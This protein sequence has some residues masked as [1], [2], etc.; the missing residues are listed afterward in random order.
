MCKR[1]SNKFGCTHD[2]SYLC[3]ELSKQKLYKMINRV[4][5]RIKVLQIVYSYYQNENSDLGISENELLFS[6][7]KSY[8]LYNY[9]LLLI[10]EVT[11]L[12]Y[13]IIEAKKSKYLPTEEEKNP[14]M[15]LVNNRLATQ[16]SA[17]DSLK[18]YVASEGISWSDDADFVKSVLDLILASDVYKEYIENPDDSYET[19]R[20][21]WRTIFKKVIGGNDDIEEYLGDKSIYW[22]DDIEIVE[23]FVM[24]TINQFEQ[25]KGSRQELLP[26]Y[27]DNEDK[28][29]ATQLFRQSILKGADYRS[30]IDYHMRNWDTE[31]VATM[32]LI[33]MQV[34]LAELL[35]FP[36]IPIEVTLN[37]YI[38]AAKFYSTPN[39]S[40]FVNGVLNS[41][42]EELKS[43]KLLLKN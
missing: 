34:A 15:R 11:N 12:Q 21:F 2:L 36:S 17:N 33:I 8:D 32:D 41:I 28:N 26:M 42:V 18:K 6:L 20:T 24:K 29:F 30:R 4:L 14:N 25:S 1:L 19:D 3:S 7:Q 10:P 40:Q 27:N 16:I 38:N 5:I 31:R 37:E 9:F 39:S 23:T 43:E 35:N 13:R 22:N